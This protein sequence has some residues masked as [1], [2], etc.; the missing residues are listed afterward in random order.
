IAVPAPVRYAEQA[1]P[2]PGLLGEGGS[3]CTIGVQP[4]P[5]SRLPPGE[6]GS[7]CTASVQPPPPSRLPPDVAARAA[8]GPKRARFSRQ[9]EDSTT[10]SMHSPRPMVVTVRWLAVLVNGSATIRRRI[11][12]GS[13]PSCSATLSIWHSKGERGCG[14]AWP[15]LGPHGGLLVKMRAA[16]NL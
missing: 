6:G 2:T 7:G 15:R 9:P 11:S 5:P 4:P 14:V 16:S 8:V 12:A 1:M 3:G 13:S 10:L